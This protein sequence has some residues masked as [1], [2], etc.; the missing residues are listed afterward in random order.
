MRTSP[1][2]RADVDGRRELAQ[3]RLGPAAQLFA[4]GVSFA[5]RFL[6]IM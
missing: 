4:L 3:L 5:E 1:S 6:R 2:E